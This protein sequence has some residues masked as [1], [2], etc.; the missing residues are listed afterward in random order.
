MPAFLLAAHLSALTASSS[1]RVPIE[2]ITGKDESIRHVL[3]TL[4]SEDVP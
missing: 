2:V 1:L 4:K 3:S